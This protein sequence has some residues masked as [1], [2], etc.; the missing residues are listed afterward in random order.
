MPFMTQ[1]CT[2][3]L[4][5]PHTPPPISVRRPPRHHQSTPEGQRAAPQGPLATSTHGIRDPISDQRG[6][7]AP[8]SPAEPTLGQPYVDVDAQDPGNPTSPPPPDPEHPPLT[9]TTIRD[10]DLLRATLQGRSLRTP[11]GRDRLQESWTKLTVKALRDLTTPDNGLHEAIVDLVLWRA[12]QHAQSQHVWIPPIEWGEA[13][14]HDTDTNVTCRGTIRLRRA[15]AENDHPAEANDPEQWEQDTGPTS[16]TAL[17]AAGLRTPDNKLPLR[18]SDSD[19]APP[20]VW[21]TVLERGHDYVVAAAATSPGPQ[22]LI[23]GT[24]TMLAPGVA[25]PGAVGD[26][27]TPH[28]VLRGAL[29]AG[30]KPPARALAKITSGRAGYHLRLAMLC[31]A[32]WIQRRWPSI[33]TVP[34]PTHKSRQAQTRGRTPPKSHSTPSPAAT[35]PSTRSSAVWALAQS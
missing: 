18:P 16:D 27:T 34:P 19:H 4:S 21:V 15:Q 32:Q 29:Q 30:D 8:P 35:T 1:K 6:H 24:D 28:R 5:A 26:P 13:L 10:A 25:P 11:L 31:L 22:W 2:N 14:T 17:R 12:G 3:A 7:P 23:K 9:P 20:E 33:G